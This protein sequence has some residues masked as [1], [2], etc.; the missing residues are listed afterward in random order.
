M[1]DE[2][3]ICK[4]VECMLHQ[5]IRTPK[6]FMFLHEQVYARTHVMLSVTTLK[7]VWGYVSY[8]HAPSLRT[9]NTLAQF[10]GF[11]D[12]KQFREKSLDEAPSDIVISN[13]IDVAE[14]LAEGDEL[15]LYWSPDR[16]CHIRCLGN[17]RFVVIASANTRLLPGNTFSCHFI[18]EGEPL[19]LSQLH[20]GDR[21]TVNY[22]CGKQGGVRFEYP[23]PTLPKG[24]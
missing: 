19:Y 13:Y 5:E 8:D 7:R 16:E 3:N 9:L 4:S 1:N 22:V 2:L 15:T 10:L 18:I 17:N 11:Q 12:Y 23:S 14:D 21:P 24:E 20:Q 6:D